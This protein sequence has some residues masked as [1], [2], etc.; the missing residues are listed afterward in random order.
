MKTY[1]YSKDRFINEMTVRNITDSNVEESPE[2]FIC[3]DPTGGPKSEPFFKENHHN[4]IKLQFDDCEQDEV[5]WGEKIQSYYDAKAMT[6][7]QAKEIIFFLKKIP[8]NAAVNI[9]CWH[10]ESR[11]VAVASLLNNKEDGNPHVLK[12]LKKAWVDYPN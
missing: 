1:V 3:I 7:D 2:F 8:S 10:G 5:K 6:F 12:L 4:V 9:Y 11:S